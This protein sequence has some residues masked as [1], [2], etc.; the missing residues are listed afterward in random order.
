[1]GSLFVFLS[2]P[3]GA[4]APAQTP[5][6]MTPYQRAVEDRLHN[7][8]ADLAHYQDQN[9]KLGP[10]KPGE[11]RVVFMGDSITEFWGQRAPAF[12]TARPYINRGISGQ[13]TPQML[14]RFRPD[15]IALRPRVVVILGGTND[16]AGNTGPETLGMIE[17][18]LMSMADLARA[19]GIQVVLA[20]VLPAYEFP[21]K[22][23]IQPADEIVAL[24]AWMKGYAAR[25]GLMY[26]DYYSAMVD[27]RGGLKA[28]LTVDGV[29]PNA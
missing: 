7:D 26:L 2:P 14:V 18:N 4:Q 21:W 12:F 1:M 11:K 25:N 16:I 23:G 28:D 15:V 27:G 5:P 22:P 29:H 20:S 3:I 17:D 6:A 13:T 19:N 8:W 24:N 10:P 9:A